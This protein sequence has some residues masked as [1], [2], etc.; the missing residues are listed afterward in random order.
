MDIIG[1]RVEEAYVAIEFSLSESKNLK[2]AL[3]NCTI[4]FDSTK[5]EDVRYHTAFMDLYNMLDDFIKEVEKD[6]Q[7]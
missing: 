4:N 5:E 1:V 2:K 3:D 6:D 7:L